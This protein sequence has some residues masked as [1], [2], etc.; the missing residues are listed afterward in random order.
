MLIWFALKTQMSLCVCVCLHRYLQCSCRRVHSLR[1]YWQYCV[2]LIKTWDKTGKG[3]KAI[4]R[5]EYENSTANYSVHS[6]L[7]SIHHVHV[8]CPACSVHSFL[9]VSSTMEKNPQYN[10]IKEINNFWTMSIRILHF[11]CTF[12]ANWETFNFKVNDGRSL[13][14]LTATSGL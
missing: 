10:L 4:N 2:W 3:W 13:R 1:K 8:Y 14:Q 11:F 9:V 5:D 7:G 12:T 6:P